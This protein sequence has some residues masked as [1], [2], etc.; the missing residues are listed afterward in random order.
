MNLFGYINFIPL[1]YIYFYFSKCKNNFL[2]LL[3]IGHWWHHACTHIL[4]GPRRGMLN[5][6]NTIT[7]R[8]SGPRAAAGSGKKPPPPTAETPNTTDHHRLPS[9]VYRPTIGRPPPEALVVLCCQFNSIVLPFCANVLQSRRGLF[10]SRLFIC[11]FVCTLV[12]HW[13]HL[14]PPQPLTPSPDSLK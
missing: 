14:A 10:V 2:S 1:K 4:A 3:Q 7:G 12:C 8:V 11:L 5:A 9:A 13:K 6:I